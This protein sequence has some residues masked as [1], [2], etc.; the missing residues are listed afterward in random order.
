MVITGLIDQDHNI[1]DWDRSHL[2]K[3]A[4]P[5]KVNSISANDSRQYTEENLD[6]ELPFMISLKQVLVII[7]ISFMYSTITTTLQYHDYKNFDD[8]T[9]HTDLQNSRSTR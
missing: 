5:D 6:E 2:I 1:L 4:S 7:T 3:V 9:L 8:T